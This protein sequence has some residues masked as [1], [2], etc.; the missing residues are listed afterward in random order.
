MI[1]PLHDHMFHVANVTVRY[2][3]TTALDGVS[4]DVVAGER[5]GLVGPSGAGKTTLLRVL[6]GTVRPTSGRAVLHGQIIASLSAREMRRLRARI[7]FIHQD[8][9]LVPNL[10]V[11]RNVLSGNLGRQSLAGSLRSMLFPTRAEARSVHRILERVGVQEK[12]YERT[13]HLSGGQQQRVAVARALF[14]EPVALLADEPVANLDPSRARD[15]VSLL[16]EISREQGLTLCMSLHR[17]ELARAFF[18]RLVG[19]RHGR[20][21]FDKRTE[22]VNEQEFGRLYQL[23]HVQMP[24]DGPNQQQEN[25]TRA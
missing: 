13:D 18:P 15:T 19:L 3:S 8:L 7:G 20:I 24:N 17:L 12:L 25:A 6:N 1:T 2:G 21:V 14:Q 16:T 10:R 5:V 4:M 11:I 23:D 9:S 22:K